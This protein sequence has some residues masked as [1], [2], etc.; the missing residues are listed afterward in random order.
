M[1]YQ[2][3]IVYIII[4]VVFFFILRNAVRLIKKSSSSDGGCNCCSGCDLGNKPTIKFKEQKE[5]KTE[6]NRDKK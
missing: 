1:N 5:D 4:A 2:D 3:I 6:C